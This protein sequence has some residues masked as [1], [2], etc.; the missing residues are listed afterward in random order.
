MS[1]A[2]KFKMPGMKFIKMTFSESSTL[3]FFSVLASSLLIKWVGMP[4]LPGTGTYFVPTP[5]L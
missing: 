4:Y 5:T 2:Q 1:K 3:F